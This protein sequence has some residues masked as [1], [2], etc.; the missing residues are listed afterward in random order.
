VIRSI[1]DSPSPASELPQ[2][3]VRQPGWTKLSARSTARAARQID[4]C[5]RTG[6]GRWKELE[7]GIV[8]TRMN[9]SA[10]RGEKTTALRADNVDLK[11]TSRSEKAGAVA[12]QPPEHPLASVK[13]GAF[14]CFD[15]CW[16]HVFLPRIRRQ[17]CIVQPDVP[18]EATGAAICHAKIRTMKAQ[19]PRCHR[20]L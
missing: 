18:A 16:Q 9:D 20:L 15:E 1:C 4:R 14:G 13:V 2:I 17:H 8:A 10:M 3:C 5:Q 7:D 11:W 6:G 12:A 19:I